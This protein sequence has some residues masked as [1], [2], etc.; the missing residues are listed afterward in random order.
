MK[1]QKKEGRSNIALIRMNFGQS[2]SLPVCD[3]MERYPGSRK[4]LPEYQIKEIRLISD[5]ITNLY[6][7]FAATKKFR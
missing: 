5:I 1:L 6:T 7:N 3:F 4:N 2:R